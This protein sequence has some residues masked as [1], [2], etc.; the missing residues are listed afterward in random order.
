MDVSHRWGCGD[1]QSEGRENARHVSS[2]PTC[3]DKIY[4]GK[5]DKPQREEVQGE[6]EDRDIAEFS[7]VQKEKCSKTG[8][9]HRETVAGD[10]RQCA[11]RQTKL[12]PQ[13]M[14][15]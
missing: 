7:Q 15:P 14:M 1:S 5:K 6:V 9:R 8:R 13:A 4:M 3:D 11:V 2:L 12:L 10:R